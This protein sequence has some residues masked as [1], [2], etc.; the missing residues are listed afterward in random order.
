ML[1]PFTSVFH[2]SFC[3]RLSLFL[4]PS[5]WR[6][7]ISCNK[8]IARTRR[9]FCALQFC[10]YNMTFFTLDYT[11]TVFFFN[12]SGARLVFW[13]SST[14]SR[15][16]RWTGR[17]KFIPYPKQSRDRRGPRGTSA[18]HQANTRTNVS[19]LLP[20]SCTTFSQAFTFKWFRW[21]IR[22]KRHR[23]K[24]LTAVKYCGLETRQ[25][26]LHLTVHLKFPVDDQLKFKRQ[27]ESS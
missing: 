6:T 7:L 5:L 14:T 25:R 15:H 21:C 24:R 9:F 1:P 2:S 27:D 26:T 20:S 19:S 3:H 10:S 22:D 11:S 8:K 23:K 13:W 4:T 17:T 16:L 18:D 12:F